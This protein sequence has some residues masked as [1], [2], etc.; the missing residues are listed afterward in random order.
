MDEKVAHLQMIQGVIDRLSQNS[1]TVKTW[2][3]TVVASI[4]AVGVIEGG[5]LFRYL[6][7][8]PISLFWW[9][10]S[11]YLIKERSYRKL[12]DLAR[13]GKV[14]NFDLNADT[15]CPITFYDRVITFS[16]PHLTIFY[17]GIALFVLM[18][19]IFLWP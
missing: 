6:P 9:L 10:D 16:S 2:T 18:A 7:A 8:L 12:Y 13:N 11:Y 15:N 19:G 17:L 4:L 14:G 5:Y 3:V 1:F